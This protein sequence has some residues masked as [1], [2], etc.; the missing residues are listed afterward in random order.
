MKHL[1]YGIAAIG[2]LA[3]S[4]PVWAQP[5]ASTTP[6]AAYSGSSPRGETS[7]ERAAPSHHMHH[8]RHAAAYHGVGRRP[9]Q[10][11]ADELNRQELTRLDRTSP[12]SVNRM[13]TGGR[14]ISGGTSR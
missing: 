9:G 6:P 5:A 1:L 10:G 3:I 8:P 13:S 11:A 2:V 4:A 12:T 14:V 7:A